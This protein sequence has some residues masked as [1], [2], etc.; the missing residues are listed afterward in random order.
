MM[1]WK[2]KLRHFRCHSIIDGRCTC[3]LGAAC[4]SAGKHPKEKGWQQEALECTPELLAAWEKDAAINL[5]I[6]CGEE[7]DILVV[8]VDGAEG[9]S[10]LHRLG[11]E[12]EPLPTT[13]TVKTGSG[14]L[15]LYFKHPHDYPQKIENK[16]RWQPGLDVRTSGGLVIASGARHLSGN[17][18]ETTIDVEPVNCPTWLLDLIVEGQATARSQKGTSKS[19]P[20]PA[21]VTVPTE[22]G[23]GAR[24]QTLFRLGSLFRRFGAT[25]SVIADF[26]LAQNQAVCK[27]PLSEKD[28]RRIAES[29]STYEP[30]TVTKESITETKLAEWFADRYQDELRYVHDLGI[31]RYWDG[32]RWAKDDT[33][34]V[35]RYVKRFIRE[36]SMTAL[37]VADDDQRR[38][39][40]AIAYKCESRQKRDALEALIKKEDALK[41]KS[42]DFDRDPML[43]NVINGTIDL[44]TQELRPHRRDDMITKLALTYRDQRTGA[45]VTAAYDRDA[46]CPLFEKFLKEIFPENTKDFTDFIQR[47]MGL[48]L[49]GLVKDGVVFLL[50][51]DGSNGKGTL[52]Y[53]VESLT[54]DYGTAV[55]FDMFIVR[56]FGG[57]SGPRDGKIAFMGR[58]FIRSSEANKGQR[59]D[60]AKIKD[61]SAPDGGLINAGVFYKENV[62]FPPTHKLWLASNHDPEI[63]GTDTGI[64]RRLKRVDFDR[65]FTEAEKDVD[66]WPK[67]LSELPGILNFALHGL[68]KYLADGRLVCPDVVKASTDA[69]RDSQDQM[70]RFLADTNDPDRTADD[71]ILASHLYSLYKTWTFENKEKYTMTQKEFGL[72]AKRRLKFKKEKTGL[73]YL[74]FKRLIVATELKD[75]E[76]I[77]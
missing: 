56:S 11:R 3:R 27:P 43:L 64:W 62:Q 39:L 15:H 66:L 9:L 52:L 63:R 25:E 2:S 60:E 13:Y 59:L 34:E 53:M 47:A 49:T 74:D 30:A 22:L 41:S 19:T 33:S 29:C 8:D 51:G 46:A 7:S 12:R 6:L 14:G 50:R 36:L 24:N 54:G 61:T 65:I 1:P 42:S 18:Y 28:V 76:S 71:R 20:S 45:I 68:V 44:N 58:R 38:F 72:E 67:L 35:S 26:L 16:V 70:A 73:Y 4:S 75:T 10:S 21:G 55:D 48:T 31:W 32:T 37:S 77:F 17:L 23:I 69:Y 5:G 40:Q 57:N